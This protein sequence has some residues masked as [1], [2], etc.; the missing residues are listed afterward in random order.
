[1]D[2]VITQ[3]FEVQAYQDLF[4]PTGFSPN[5]DGI[6][7]CWNVRGI[8]A[9]PNNSVKIYNR[10]NTLVYDKED[11][12]SGWC[13]QNEN[14]ISYGDGELPEGTYFYILDFGDGSEPRNGFIYLKR[15]R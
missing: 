8:N 4:I 11:Y 5:N 6:N 9:F 3:P 15:S 10:W 14:G 13:G 7:D 2:D 12:R 1:M